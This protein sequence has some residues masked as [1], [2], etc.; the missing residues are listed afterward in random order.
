M[1]KELKHNRTIGRKNELLRRRI[2]AALKAQLVEI[3]RPSDVARM[4]NISKQH[5]NL[6]TDKA[7]FRCFALMT[8][9]E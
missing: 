6:I 8:Y 3:T 2:G 5:V 1:I 9:D 7:L 4:L